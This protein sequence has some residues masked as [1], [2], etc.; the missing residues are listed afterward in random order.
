MTKRE[1]TKGES[2]RIT[3]GFGSTDSPLAFMLGMRC[4]SEAL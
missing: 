3:E 1:V 4:D 2:K